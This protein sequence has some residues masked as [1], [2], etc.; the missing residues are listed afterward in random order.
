VNVEGHGKR[1]RR[2]CRGGADDAGGDV[3]VHRAGRGAAPGSHVRA[4]A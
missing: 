1:R 4:S 2:A 3:K